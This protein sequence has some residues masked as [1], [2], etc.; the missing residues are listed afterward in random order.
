MNEHPKNAME[1]A[2]DAPAG[3]TF[4]E[5][6]GVLELAR[7]QRIQQCSAALQQVLDAHGCRLEPVVTIK[8][9]QILSQ[10]VVVS[11]T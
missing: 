8:G 7:A 10:I 4:E 1:C 5:A 11:R 9:N 3:P 6:Y 2:P